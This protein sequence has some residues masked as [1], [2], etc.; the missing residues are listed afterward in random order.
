MGRRFLVGMCS[1]ST[2]WPFRRFEPG[3]GPAAAVPPSGVMKAQRFIRWPHRRIVEMQ[4]HVEA[5][6]LSGLEIPHSISR[7]QHLP[8]TVID[9]SAQTLVVGADE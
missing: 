1:R 5:Q 7:P 2:R 4:G 6:R 9:Y 3:S 8:S